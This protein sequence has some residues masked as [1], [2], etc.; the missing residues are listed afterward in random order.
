MNHVYA[1]PAGTQFILADARLTLEE[2]G[3]EFVAGREGV[4]EAVHRYLFNLG[5]RGYL[6]RPEP[7]LAQAAD[8]LTMKVRLPSCRTTTPVVESGLGRWE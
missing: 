3:M 6:E 1:Q 2:H 4:N 5:E 7:D 8:E